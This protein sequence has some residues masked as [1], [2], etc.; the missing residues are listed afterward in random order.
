MSLKTDVFLQNRPAALLSFLCDATSLNVNNH[1]SEKKL[2]PFDRTV[3]F[4]QKW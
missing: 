2:Y 1:T 4:H 3:I